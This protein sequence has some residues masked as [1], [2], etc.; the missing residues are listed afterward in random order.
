MSDATTLPA[1]PLMNAIW[2]KIAAKRAQLERERRE[3]LLG[4]GVYFTESA[5]WWFEQASISTISASRD[6]RACRQTALHSATAAHLCA[7][8]LITL[9]NTP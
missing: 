9:E 7:L 1:F 2:T 6:V 5:A 4:M 3:E 8:T